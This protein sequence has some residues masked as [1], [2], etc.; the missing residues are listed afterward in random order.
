MTTQLTVSAAVAAQA[1]GDVAQVVASLPVSLHPAAERADL[2]AIS[3]EDGWPVAAAD[4]IASGA[5]GVLVVDPVAADVAD[6][7]ERATEA[8]VPVVLDSTWSDNP[9][10]A[11]AADAF[12]AQHDPDSFAEARV[13]APLGSDL[14]RVLLNQLSLVRTALAP[15][16]RIRFARRNER[17]YDAV[18]ELTSGV[19]SGLS[20]ILSDALPHSASLRVLRSETAVELALPA[21]VTAA[22]GQVTVSGPEG[23]TL[24]PT[25]WETAHRG[26]WRRLHRLVEAGET[27]GDLA[28][29]AGDVTAMRSAV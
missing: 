29:F 10:V 18:A 25:L 1:A 7:I 12:A 26:A 19:T 23:A 14:D 2:V 11:G 8:G 21:P 6:L 15:V 5:R 9:A 3:G 27:A 28:G 24:L 20:A 16:A 13:D 22:P 17:G 4:A